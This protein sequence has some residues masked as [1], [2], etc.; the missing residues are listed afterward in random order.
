MHPYWKPRCIVCARVANLECTDPEQRP[1]GNK[2]A[3]RRR[4]GGRKSPE[5]SLRRIITPFLIQIFENP[6]RAH[7]SA[8]AHGDHAV[9]GVATLQFADH[10]GR[11]LGSSASQR[12]S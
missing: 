5:P 3:E 4:E 7:A 10:A 2:T 9:A 1:T 6:S 11:Q 8:D 12:M